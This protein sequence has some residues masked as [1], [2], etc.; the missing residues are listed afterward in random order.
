MGA[1]PMWHGLREGHRNDEKEPEWFHCLRLRY[2]R[3]STRTGAGRYLQKMWWE[4]G[5][6][7]DR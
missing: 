5:A 6:G 4:K 2:T 3:T 7:Y 1:L